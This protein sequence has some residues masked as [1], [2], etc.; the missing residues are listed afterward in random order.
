MVSHIILYKLSFEDLFYP[1]IGH[2]QVQPLRVR[3]DMSKCNT[4]NKYES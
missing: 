2:E 1:Y 4:G 3:V